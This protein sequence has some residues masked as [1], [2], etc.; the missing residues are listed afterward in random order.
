[1]KDTG[2][3][4]NP[5]QS[6]VP[7]LRQDWLC[8]QPG[9]TSQ[10]AQP[11]RDHPFCLQGLRYLRGGQATDRQ[12]ASQI[13]RPAESRPP[14]HRQFQR[15]GAREGVLPDVSRGRIRN[16]GMHR[17]DLRHHRPAQESQAR[18]PR[19]RGR[20]GRRGDPAGCAPRPVP[21]RRVRDTGGGR[22]G[23]CRRPRRESANLLRTKAIIL[24]RSSYQRT[25]RSKKYRRVLLICTN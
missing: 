8:H 13:D 17:Q 22:A 24:F 9:E 4:Y 23:L 18:G 10:A 3:I 5:Y 15:Q 7:R 20:D 25:G 16:P 19:D 2:C 6:V 14:D 11:E 12:G 1:M 21:L